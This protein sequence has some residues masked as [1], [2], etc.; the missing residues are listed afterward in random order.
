MHRVLQRQTCTV[1]YKMFDPAM[2]ATDRIQ[3]AG[4][5]IGLYPTISFGRKDERS[6]CNEIKIINPIT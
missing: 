2:R 4:Q 3:V 1:I 5:N 6:S